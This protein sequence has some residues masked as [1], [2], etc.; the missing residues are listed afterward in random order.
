MCFRDKYGLL[1]SYMLIIRSSLAEI[2]NRFNDNI[3]HILIKCREFIKL[4]HLNIITNKAVF[5]FNRSFC[6]FC[7]FLTFT[8]EGQQLKYFDI[9][10]H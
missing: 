7:L 4:C 3:L 10:S 1:C 9:N 5:L 2:I 8:L 6:A